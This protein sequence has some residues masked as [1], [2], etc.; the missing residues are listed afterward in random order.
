MRLSLLRVRRSHRTHLVAGATI[1]AL[2]RIDYVDIALADG[3]SGT[4]RL[5]RPAG[6]ALIVNFER[7]FRPSFRGIIPASLYTMK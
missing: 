5:A 6:N 1:N 4:L 7:H 3:V 2:I